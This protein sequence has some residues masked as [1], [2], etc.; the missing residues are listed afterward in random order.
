M[1]VAY[2][3]IGFAAGLGLFALM[4]RIAAVYLWAGDLRIDR[5]DDRPYLFLEMSKNVEWLIKQKIVV[6]KVNPNSYV[7]RN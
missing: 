5:S 3:L 1:A 2:I 6:L 7:T 4:L